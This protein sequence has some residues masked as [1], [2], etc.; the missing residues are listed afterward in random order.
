MITLYIT[1]FIINYVNPRQIYRDGG[2]KINNNFLYIS[3]Y[4]FY[5]L[6]NFGEKDNSSLFVLM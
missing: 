1:L 6:T 5:N 4:L 2:K 3:S